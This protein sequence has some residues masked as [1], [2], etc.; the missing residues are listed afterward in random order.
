MIIKIIDVKTVRKDTT[1]ISILSN[2]LRT[3]MELKIVN[4]I[5]HKIHVQ[6]VNNIIIQLIINV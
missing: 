1:L 6:Y 4:N 2:V 5:T 3:L